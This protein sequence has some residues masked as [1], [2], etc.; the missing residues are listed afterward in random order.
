MDAINNVITHNGTTGL[1]AWD[2]AATGRFINNVVTDNGWYSEEWVGKKTGIW[3][4]S[5]NVELAYND[6]WGNEEE[7]VCSGGYPGSTA[8]TAIEFIDQDGNLSVDPEFTDE[9]DFAL[10][11]GS[12][13]I[14]A[15]DP[16]ILDTDGTV[17]DMG[18]HGGPDAGLVLP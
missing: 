9:A 16:A 18:A 13:L 3:M 10:D 7:D 2:S 12:P 5:E 11:S 1:A 15:G 6:V 14:D 4:N 17:S 8:C